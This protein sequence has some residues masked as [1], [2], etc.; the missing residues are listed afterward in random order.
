LPEGARTDDDT[1]F[2]WVYIIEMQRAG[3][4]LLPSDFVA[5]LWRSRI[6]RRIWCSNQYA[7]QLMD[8]GIEPP[9]TGRFALNPW[10]DFNISGQFICETFGLLAPGMPNSA[11]EIGLNYTHVTIDQEPAQT[12]Q[13]FTTMIATAFFEDNIDS[14]LDA[15]LAAIDPGSKLNGIIADVRHW[16]EQHPDKW[17][18]TRRLVKDKYSKY[19]GEMRDRN[20]YELNTASTI[21]ALLYGQGDFAETLKTA[22]NFGWDC[23]NSAATAGTI[24]GVMKGYRWMLSQGWPVVDRYRNTT[25]ENMPMDETITSFADRVIELAE[26]VILENGGKR[27]KLGG[28]PGFVVA[29]QVPRNQVPLPSLASQISDMQASMGKQIENWLVNGLG[30]QDRARA[31]YLAICLDMADEL[32]TQHPSAWEDGL[33]AL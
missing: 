4:V 32:K 33:A 26:K 12:T 16:H 24:V 15:G 22:F 17:R 18:T 9:L 13:L 8:L 10:A 11:A 23:D 3:K 25:R 31:T 5:D 21:A 14:I 30:R 6:N 28:R 20:G 27:L 1:D 29:G 7:R 2:E 19:N